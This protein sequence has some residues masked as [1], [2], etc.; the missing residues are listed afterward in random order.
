[1]P[2]KTVERTAV[3]PGTFDPIT[4]GHIDI[5]RRAS[6][7]VDR[8]VVAIAPNP[9]KAPLFSAGE[10]LEMVQAATANLPHVTVDL[11]DGLLI[12]YLEQKK[13]GVILRGIRAFSD[14]EF[15]FQM[16]LMNRKLNADIETLF[17]MPSEEY[18]YVTSTLVKEV[19]SYG[20]N[21]SAFV[22][23][24]VVSRLHRKFFQKTK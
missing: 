10:R 9:K 2:K 14:F 22:P 13:A 3:Y 21:V 8:V 12:H 11:F 15:E 4:N 6:K 20:G 7:V 23:K 17:L 18:A 16:A 19:A 24:G 1:M 5:I